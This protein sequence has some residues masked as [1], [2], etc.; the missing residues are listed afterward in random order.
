LG[1]DLRGD[2][3]AFQWLAQPFADFFLT[4]ARKLALSVIAGAAVVDVLLFLYVP[5]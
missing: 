2:L 4:E 5:G 3:K 1:D